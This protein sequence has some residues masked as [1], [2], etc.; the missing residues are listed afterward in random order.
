MKHF[1]RRQWLTLPNS[2]HGRHNMATYLGKCHLQATLQQA[3]HHKVSLHN[4]AKFRTAQCHI[5]INNSLV[6]NLHIR[7]ARLHLNIIHL[8]DLGLA[9]HCNKMSTV[10]IQP[11]CRQELLHH[12][13]RISLPNTPHR[14]WELQ[15]MIR[16]SITDSHPEQT[17]FRLTC[18]HKSTTR[19]I[20]LRCTLL[21]KSI[22]HNHLFS[23]HRRVTP[24]AHRSNKFMSHLHNTNISNPPHI[25]PRRLLSRQLLLSLSRQRTL[26]FLS[27]NHRDTKHIKGLTPM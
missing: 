7:S 22:N 20:H 1:L 4:L 26:L 21:Q 2:M 13:S 15:L 18:S 14:K 8:Q 5:L 6:D 17:L 19:I 25:S 12:N 11:S 24:Q 3:I 10:L 27:N 9:N 23:R 16:L